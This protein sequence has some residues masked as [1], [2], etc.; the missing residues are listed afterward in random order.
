MKL[1]KT[2]CDK[3][4][5]FHY[6]DSHHI[7]PKGIY[8]GE[9]ETVNLCKNCHDEL[10]RYIGYKYS[11]KKHKQPREFYYRKYSFWISMILIIGI[12]LYYMNS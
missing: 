3:C 11:R 4:G 9:G 1:R 10:H 6:C 12:I 5:E 8:E 2:Q 7:L